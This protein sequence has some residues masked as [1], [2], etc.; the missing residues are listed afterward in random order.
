MVSFCAAA[1]CRADSD[2]AGGVRCALPPCARAPGPGRRGRGGGR[3]AGAARAGGST[4]CTY[5]FT[6][7]ILREYI[8][9]ENNSIRI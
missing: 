6:A 2:A 4:L 1:R 9:Q 3:P 8:R 5:H 7:L